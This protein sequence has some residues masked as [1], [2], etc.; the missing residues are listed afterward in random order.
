[1][2]KSKNSVD[3]IVI[4]HRQNPL[5]VNRRLYWRRSKDTRL[6]GDFLPSHSR[7]QKRMCVLYFYQIK[8][9]KIKF[10][11]SPFNSFRVVTCVQTDWQSEFN[12]RSGRDVNAPNSHSEICSYV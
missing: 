12:R 2:T 1:M 3:Q 6:P 11:D 5:L 7:A 9:N 10:G 8:K 4:H